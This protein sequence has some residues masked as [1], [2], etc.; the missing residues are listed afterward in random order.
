M[1][2]RNH[3][4]AQTNFLTQL[5]KNSS[6]YIIIISRILT[7][8]LSI[9]SCVKLVIYIF[10]IFQQLHI[11]SAGSIIKIIGLTVWRVDLI[12][13][14]CGEKNHSAQTINILCIPFGCISVK[15]SDKHG[16]LSILKPKQIC[17]VYVKLE[18]CQINEIYLPEQLMVCRYIRIF[19]ILSYNTTNYVLCLWLLMENKIH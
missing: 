11:I 9:N 2:A 5:D 18:K 15:V 8:I 12:V 3:A 6:E 17:F 4:L 19:L 13:V 16:K 7:V 10:N 14:A 1:P